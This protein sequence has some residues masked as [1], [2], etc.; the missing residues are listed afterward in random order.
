MLTQAIPVVVGVSVI[1]TTNLLFD[2]NQETLSD[3]LISISDWTFGKPP[4]YDRLQ[5]TGDRVGL[6]YLVSFVAIFIL[7]GIRQ[8]LYEEQCLKVLSDG[9]HDLLINTSNNFRKLEMKIFVVM[10]F[11]YGGLLFL[12]EPL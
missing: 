11:H 12:N 9:F 5:K 8:V 7:I 6:V 4:G 3:L 2:C 1:N 10:W